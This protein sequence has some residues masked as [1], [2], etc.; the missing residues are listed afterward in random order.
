MN[1]GNGAPAAIGLEKHLTFIFTVSK[2]GYIM[3]YKIIRLTL[4][5][6]IQDY[7]SNSMCA[8]DYVFMQAG[9]EVLGSTEQEME[10][11]AKADSDN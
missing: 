9:A 6:A 8:M 2:K 11:H 7:G 5:V 4:D 10:L 1:L 3:D